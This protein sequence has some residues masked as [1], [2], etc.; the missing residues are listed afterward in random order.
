MEQMFHDMIPYRADHWLGV[1]NSIV[2]DLDLPAARTRI[3][4]TTTWREPFVH[5]VD[6]QSFKKIHVTV[7]ENVG[8]FRSYYSYRPNL[9]PLGNQYSRER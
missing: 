4:P 1:G 3:A 9:S 6:F 2:V 8:S 7:A 5:N